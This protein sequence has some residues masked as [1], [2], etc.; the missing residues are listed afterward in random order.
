MSTVDQISE[1]RFEYGVGRS[2]NARSYD[3]MGIPYD[4]SRERF[5][6]ALD[7]IMEAWKGNLFPIT[8]SITTLRMHQ[9]PSVSPLP[10]QKPHPKIRLASTSEDSFARVGRLG[11]P[12]FLSMR[13]MDVHD[14]ETNLKD[15]LKAW[16]EAGHLGDAGDVS[17]RI[18]VYVGLTEEEAIE[19]PRE[20]IEAYLDRMR[21]LG[22]GEAARFQRSAS[23]AERL[24]K[25]TY[26]EI[27]ETKVIFG[28]PARVIDRLTQFKETLGLTD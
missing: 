11:F 9:C 13:G 10:Y 20:S 7:I 22:D 28:T 19:D 27:L 26:Q 3:I 2:G 8:A 1:G 14:L 21:R 17:V 25:I 18:P 5:Q 15:Y 23:R 16:R 6:K 24:A 12:I 4:E